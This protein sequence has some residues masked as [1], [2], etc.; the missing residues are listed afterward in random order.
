MTPFRLLISHV[1]IVISIND[2]SSQEIYMN[3]PPLQPTKKLEEVASPLLHPV[4]KAI[5]SPLFDS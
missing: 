1:V 5:A 2:M 3:I 4:M